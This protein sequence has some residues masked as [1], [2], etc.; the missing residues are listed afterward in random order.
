MTVPVTVPLTAAMIC[1]VLGFCGGLV[2]FA[3]LKASLRFTDWRLLAAAALLRLAAAGFL[4]WLAARQG[5]LP[6]L[7]ALA[8]FLAARAV[9][10]RRSDPKAAKPPG[11][12]P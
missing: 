3:A 6:L 11:G 7:A 2:Y 12:P 4:L 9:M 10:V 8:G 5:A 1:A